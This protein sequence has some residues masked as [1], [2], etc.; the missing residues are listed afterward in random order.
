MNGLLMAQSPPITCGKI[1]IDFNK[2]ALGI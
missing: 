1:E 2:V